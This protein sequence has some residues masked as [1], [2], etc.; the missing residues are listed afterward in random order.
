MQQIQSRNM[1]VKVQTVDGRIFLD[2]WTLN[3][4]GKRSM[5]QGSNDQIYELTMDELKEIIT[6]Y[7]RRNPELS[8]TTESQYIN[9]LE[10]LY[11]K[12]LNDMSEE[13]KFAFY[14]KNGMSESEAMEMIAASQVINSWDIELPDVDG[15]SL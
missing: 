4:L 3:A 10:N 15:M 7:R 13:E 14:I 8:V 11:L 6:A 9:S 5:V 2:G 1:I 12:S